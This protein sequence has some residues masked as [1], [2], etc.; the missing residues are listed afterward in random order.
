MQSSTK[1]MRS[2]FV[3]LWSQLG[4]FWGVPATSTARVYAWLL[5]CPDGTGAD[6]EELMH[7][8]R[9]SHGAVSM[10]CKELRDCGLATAMQESG[11]RRSRHT[12]V[13]DLT[14]VI[15]TSTGRGSVESGIPFST[16]SGT[17]SRG[18]N[19]TT[20]QPRLPSGT[21]WNRLK[22]ASVW[23]TGWPNGFWTAAS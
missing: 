10:A 2:E 20:R 17:G 7:S 8:L 5:S 6:S 19:R 3:Q 11:A 15:R 23:P 4:Q 14:T 16:A 12:A 21:G 1:E 13:A 22:P 18:W 9:M